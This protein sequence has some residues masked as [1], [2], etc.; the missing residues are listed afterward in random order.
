ME[1][2]ESCGGELDLFL[3]DGVPF[4][5][6][7]RESKTVMV[8]IVS[9]E[10]ANGVDPS[11]VLSLSGVSEPRFGRDWMVGLPDTG[12]SPVSSPG[13]TGWPD[14][15]SS[16]PDFVFS[17]EIESRNWEGEPALCSPAS[18][19]RIP[20]SLR[21]DTCLRLPH[22]IRLAI[23]G[24]CVLPFLMTTL[25][26]CWASLLEK[27]NV[28]IVQYWHR[29]A[30]FR[31]RI[32]HVHKDDFRWGE[33]VGPVVIELFVKGF[34]GRYCVLSVIVWS[35]WRGWRCVSLTGSTCTCGSCGAFESVGVVSSPLHDNW[36]ELR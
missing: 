33:I 23:T 34:S 18:E 32:V 27:G 35:G 4:V 15:T 25:C 17:Q 36:R 29:G 31:Q 19:S 2:S 9:A 3:G 7:E 5:P 26:S 24:I 21:V 22:V 30:S 1:T 6:R 11:V 20:R 13:D 16:A 8:V 28:F 10:L 12:V 14:R